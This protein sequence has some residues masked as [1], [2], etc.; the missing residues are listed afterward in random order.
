M[1]A[2][3]GRGYYFFLYFFSF[4]SVEGGGQCF[5]PV[6]RPRRTAEQHFAT[7]F[8][9]PNAM[10]CPKPQV[11]VP[12]AFATAAP[13]R[14][15]SPPLGDLVSV[16]GLSKSRNPSLGAW[17]LQVCFTRL[18]S[19]SAN[20]FSHAP[21]SISS[22]FLWLRQRVANHFFALFR[23]LCFWPYFWVKYWKSCEEFAWPRWKATGRLPCRWGF[24]KLTWRG[25]N[26]L[27]LLEKGS[28]YTNNIICKI[29]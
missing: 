6:L 13:P 2:S 27:K 12:A 20:F 22:S 28:R 5:A 16:C 21:R 11:P 9:A 17:L 4:P 7:C 29:K 25:E 24:R 15:H 3:K 1:P 23:F 26:A 19:V 10:P 14:L 8:G 18:V